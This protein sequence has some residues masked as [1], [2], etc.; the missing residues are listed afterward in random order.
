M[1]DEQQQKKN[2][3]NECDYYHV[4]KCYFDHKHASASSYCHA[5][6]YELASVCESDDCAKCQQFL[7]GCSGDRDKAPKSLKINPHIGQK[8]VIDSKANIIAL[9]AGSQS[10]KTSLAPYWLYQE[11]MRCGNGDYLVVSPTYPLQDKK[12]LPVYLEFFVTI[13]KIGHYKVAKRILEIDGGGLKGNIF[14][15]SAE[16]PESLESATALAAH[17]DEAGQ[18]K[19]RLSAWE[20]I[21]R[22]I[23]RNQGRILITTTP[24]NFGWL[25]TE[26]YKR[27]KDGDPEIEVIQFDSKDS[28]GFSRRKYDEMKRKMPKWRFDMFLRGIFARPSGLILSDFNDEIHWINPFP[29]PEKWAW[30]LAIDPG[31]IHKAVGWFAEDPNNRKYYLVHSYLDGY[32]TTREFADKIIRYPAFNKLKRRVGGAGSEEQFRIDMRAMGVNVQ[33]PEISDVEAGLDKLIALIRENRFFVLN[34]HENRAW[35][36]EAG[37]Y[38][39]ELD[40]ETNEPTD[41]I[42]NKSKYHL[43]DMT[44]YFA[45]GTSSQFDSSRLL[46][47]VSR[48]GRGRWR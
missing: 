10:G 19:F 43:I 17:L 8:Y 6:L 5:Q 41:K 29:I 16:K 45:V 40:P 31:G 39:R 1:A 37:T 32:K 12:L 48:R 33:E 21:N 42:E 25:Y 4:G 3:C 18:D 38:S 24:Y 46:T 13:L 47:V 22:R 34:T 27:W 36:D 11:M 35:L 28:P 14:F 23:S 26:V 2:R 30:H 15:G 44:R 9:I 20:A 7:K